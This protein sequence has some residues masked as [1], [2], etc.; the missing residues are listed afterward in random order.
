MRIIFIILR[1]IFCLEG[2][3]YLGVDWWKECVGLKGRRW[4][5]AGRGQIL[6][7]GN[8]H[9]FTGRTSCDAIDSVIVVDEPYWSILCATV[10]Y[11]KQQKI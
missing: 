4:G 10:E 3:R 9:D 2:C 11:S 5:H 6:A 1:Q 8:S 7:I